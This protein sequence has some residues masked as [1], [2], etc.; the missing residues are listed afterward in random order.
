MDLFVLSRPREILVVEDSAADTKMVLWALDKNKR[1]KSVVTLI[2]GEQVMAY[3]RR[4]CDGFLP[5]LMLLDLNLPKK[6]G[7][8]VLAEC[9]ADPRLRCIPIVAFSTTQ[10]PSDVRRCYELGANSFVCKPFELVE[11]Q[12]AIGLIEDYWLRLSLAAG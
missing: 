2:D 1:G 10:L 7:W 9:K 8:Q 5:D 6:D 4:R 3:L 11:F 12:R